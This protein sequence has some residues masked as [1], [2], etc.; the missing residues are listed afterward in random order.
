MLGR[1]GALGGATNI[2]YLLLFYLKGLSLFNILKYSFS[3]R[4][5]FSKLL[6]KD[7]NDII[8]INI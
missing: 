2:T 5:F 8:N 1:L 6:S 4:F 7:N 3:N